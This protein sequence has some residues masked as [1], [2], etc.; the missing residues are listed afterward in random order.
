MSC[1]HWF[2]STRRSGAAGNEQALA[3]VL[4]QEVCRVSGS[5][6]KKIPFVLR[7]STHEKPF[8]SN[9]TGKEKGRSQ[10]RN[11]LFDIWLNRVDEFRNC[12]LYENIPETNA[13]F[14]A[15]ELAIARM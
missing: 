9:L 2:S 13:Q 11:G 5:L 12:F 6:I 10:V 3:A 1:F 7:V 4:K 15:V 8:F 14:Q